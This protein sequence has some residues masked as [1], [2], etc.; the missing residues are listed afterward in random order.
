MAIYMVV[1]NRRNIFYNFDVMPTTTVIHFLLGVGLVVTV[2]I[3]MVLGIVS[4]NIQED[5]G[6]N[7]GKFFTIRR[8]HENMARCVY[9]M[10]KGQ[11]VLGWWIYEG[12]FAL[13]IGLLFGW[14]FV[15]GVL[16]LVLEVSY[17]KHILF[18]KRNFRQEL[19]QSST[20]N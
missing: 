17:K 18:F 9:V 1:L 10:T 15:V 12:G 20:H 2:L 5:P 7:V 3:V 4:K 11:M 14:Y 19:P 13:L 6:R 16:M 8:V